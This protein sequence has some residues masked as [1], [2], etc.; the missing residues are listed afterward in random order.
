MPAVGGS[1]ESVTLDSRSFAVAA[2][3]EAE[4]NLGGFSNEFQ[5]NGDGTGRM[6]KTRNG[7]TLSGITIEI[8]DMR[9]DSE[10]LQEL[11]DRPDFFP[12]TITYAG[13]QTYQGTGT[14]VEELTSS[15]QS[16]TGDISLAGPGVLTVQ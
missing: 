6:I 15:S 4:R 10:Y 2:D 16:A 14:I 7:W 12:V 11:A 8:D 13:G 5:A 9:G 1:I 3:A